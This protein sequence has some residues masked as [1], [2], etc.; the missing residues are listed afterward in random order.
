MGMFRVF[1]LVTAAAMVVAI[2]I[3]REPEDARQAR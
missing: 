3:V 1:A 2:A